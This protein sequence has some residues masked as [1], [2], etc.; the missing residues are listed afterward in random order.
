MR[1]QRGVKRRERLVKLV[2]ESA[3]FMSALSAVRNL[4]FPLGASAPERTNHGTRSTLNSLHL[5]PQHHLINQILLLP[6]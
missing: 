4:V 3:W 6:L 1:Q 2:D 5:Q